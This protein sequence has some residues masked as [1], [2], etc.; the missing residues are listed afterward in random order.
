MAKCL[1]T[2]LIGE[3]M[4]HD[5]IAKAEKRYY[6]DNEFRARVEEV[7]NTMM[8][9]IS[10]DISDLGKSIQQSQRIL[11]RMTAATALYMEDLT[12]EET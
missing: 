9:A 10:H 1:D 4:E 8:N 12:K 7:V 6:V 11:V 5:L 2:M 3:V